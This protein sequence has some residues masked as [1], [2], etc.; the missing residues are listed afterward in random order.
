[1]PECSDPYLVGCRT[2]VPDMGMCDS[3]RRASDRELDERG[4]ALDVKSRNAERAGYPG[5]TSWP[6][7][8]SIEP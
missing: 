5:L 6:K 8:R 3:C 7:R 2:P 1:M 4:R